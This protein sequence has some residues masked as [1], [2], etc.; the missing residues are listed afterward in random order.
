MVCI[1]FSLTALTFC[2][3]YQ[4]TTSVT[5]QLQPHNIFK[6]YVLWCR[7]VQWKEILAIQSGLTVH[8]IASQWQYC[9]YAYALI[10]YNTTHSK[11]KW[12]H[13]ISKVSHMYMLK[14]PYILRPQ[15]R[16][17]SQGVPQCERV[18]KLAL[19][20]QK[21]SEVEMLQC[22]RRWKV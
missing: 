3:R 15:E 22:I 2:C 7:L 16:L 6:A 5:C 11:N 20:F 12:L 4:N 10:E 18:N 1:G 9:E 8:K 14:W 13:Q 21:L 19:Q 17:E